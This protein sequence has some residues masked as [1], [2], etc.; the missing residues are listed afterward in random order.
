MCRKANKLSP[1][2]THWYVK[3]PAIMSCVLYI[4]VRQCA[5]GMHLHKK[6]ESSS[7]HR[8]ALQVQNTFYF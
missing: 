6:T 2:I 3:E 4:F 7:V 8:G 1:T 5:F